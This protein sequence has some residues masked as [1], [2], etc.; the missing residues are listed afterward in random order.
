M[1]WARMSQAERD[2][3]Y[4]NT[5]ACP[6]AA[7]RVAG[8]TTAS[9]ATRARPGSYLDVPYAEGER[10][11]WDLF[12]AARAD[13][14]CLVF[15]HGGYWQRN[16]REMFACMAEGVLAHGWSAALPGY[17]L[18]PDASLSRIVQEIGTA[19]D[20]LLSHRQANGIS[21]PVVISGWSAGAHLATLLLAHPVISAGLAVSG[22]YELAPIA[23]TYLDDK[24]RLTPAEIATLSPLRLPVTAKPLS[25]TCG[26]N[27]LPRLVADSRALHAKRTAACAPGSLLPLDGHD[28]FSILEELRSPDGRL[29][30]AT[31]ALV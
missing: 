2:A 25:I 26:E 30:R 3:A 24:L 9:A 5:A 29:T 31:L 4:N 23:E 19:L 1:D 28:H 21:G 27:E 17:T 10:T 20:W 16:S 8:W 6:D 7:A 22:V 12:P 13:A 14:P 18:A 15:I 11:R